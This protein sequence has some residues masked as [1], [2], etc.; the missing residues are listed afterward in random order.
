[1]KLKTINITITCLFCFLSVFAQKNSL[2]PNTPSKAPDYFCTWNLQG[3]LVSHQNTQLTRK[4]MNERN[5]FGK[6]KYQNWVN[7]YPTIREDLYFVLDDSWDI[8]K[9]VMISQTPFWAQ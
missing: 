9:D 1:M 6:G 3:Y 2:I 8:P 5:L 7:C 4:A